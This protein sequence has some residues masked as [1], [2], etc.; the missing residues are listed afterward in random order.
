MS[1]MHPLTRWRRAEG[2]GTREAA[3]RLQVTHPTIINW[4]E[5]THF[6]RAKT[7]TRIAKIMGLDKPTLIRQWKDWQAKQRHNR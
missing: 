4:E 5:G 7:M 2:L 1:R 3:K 6:P